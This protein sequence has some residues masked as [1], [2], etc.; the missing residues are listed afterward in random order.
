MADHLFVPQTT[1]DAWSDQGKIDVDGVQLTILAEKKSYQLTPAV[2][3]V[4]V[5]DGASADPHGLIKKVKTEAALKQMGAEH[6]ADSVILGEIAYEVQQGF[7]AAAGAIGSVVGR[8]LAAAPAVAQPAAP[9]APAPAAPAAP[10]KK[11]EEELLTQFLL[12]NLL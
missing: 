1:L 11:D 6:M 8:P 4:R 5:V 10:Q 12:S 9:T 3:F 2:R 7:L